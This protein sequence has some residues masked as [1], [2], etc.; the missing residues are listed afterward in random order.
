MSSAGGKKIL[1]RADGNNEIG[2]GHLYRCLAIAERI[3]EDFNTFLAIQSPTEEIIKEA[4]K[5]TTVISLPKN[6]NYVSDAEYI[7]QKVIP[8]IHPSIIVLDGYSFDSNYQ[9]TLKQA[10]TAKLVCINDGQAFGNNADVVINHADGINP[11]QLASSGST[12]IYTGSKYALLR[13]PFIDEAKKERRIDKIENLFVCF[14]GADTSRITLKV[15]K[16]AVEAFSFSHIKVVVGSNYSGDNEFREFVTGHSEIESFS[17]LGVNEMIGLMNS[18]ELAIVPAS[19]IA[20]EC[21]MCKMMMITGTTVDNQLLIYNGLKTLPFVTGIDDFLTISAAVLT[22]C[23]KS[24]VQNFK[25]YLFQ[26][27]ITGSDPILDL[28]KSLV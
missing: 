17:N 11:E 15:L 28:F 7:A 12:K 14:G 13:K 21:R 8:S 3:K 5:Y 22:S 1:F 18:C 9:H 2:L 6:E 4:S 10:T 16:A 26:P 24:T 23:I 25:G 20:L 27:F 19:T